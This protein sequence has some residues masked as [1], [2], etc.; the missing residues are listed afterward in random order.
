LNEIP[1]RQELHCREVRPGRGRREGVMKYFKKPSV[2]PELVTCAHFGGGGDLGTYR[3]CHKPATRA[4]SC[5]PRNYKGEV[6]YH[7]IGHFYCA[8]HAPHDA[9]VIV[10]N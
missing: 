10:V 1:S 4:T 3:W 9:D 5:L 6:P 2:P 8:E 7:Q